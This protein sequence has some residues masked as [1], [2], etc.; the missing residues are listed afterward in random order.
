[1]VMLLFVGIGS[2]MAEEIHF[3]PSTYARQNNPSNATWDGSKTLSWN[4]S[5]GNNVLIIKNYGASTDLSEYHLVIKTSNLTA[6]FYRVVIFT[7]DNTNQVIATLSTT[8]TFYYKLY[9]AVPS[10]SVYKIAIAG[11]NVADKAGSVDIDDVYLYRADKAPYDNDGEYS[12]DLS[13]LEAAGGLSYSYDS[14]TGK[15]TLSAATASTAGT[16]TYTFDEDEVYDF[17]DVTQFT[18]TC[19][20]GNNSTTD[21]LNFYSYGSTNGSF[22]IVASRFSWNASSKNEQQSK[23]L[24][25]LGKLVW[26]RSDTNANT[27]DVVI[28]SIKFKT[29]ASL[30]KAENALASQSLTA[31]S[32]TGT[33]N[34]TNIGNSATNVQNVWGHSSVLANNYND[35]TGYKNITVTGGSANQVIR[36]LFNRA[37]DSSNLTTVSVGSSTGMISQDYT[38]LDYRITLDADGNGTFDFSKLSVAHLHAIKYVNSNQKSPTDITVGRDVYSEK[39]L[40]GSGSLYSASALALLNSEG[41]TVIDARSLGTSTELSVANPNCLILSK[42]KVSNTNNVIVDGTCANLVLTDGYPYEAPVDF[43]ATAASYTTTI[44]TT[45]QA[46]TLCLPFAATIPAEVDAYTL[47]FTSGTAATATS[48]E[49]TIPANT[50]VLLNG[51]GEQTFTGSGSID[52][53]AANTDGALTGVFKSTTVPINSYVLQNGASGL[54]FYKVASAITAKPFRAYLT[55]E[56]GSAREFFGIDFADDDITTGIRSLTPSPSPKGEGSIYTLN[57]Q[58]VAQPTKGLYIVNGKKYVIK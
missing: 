45:A 33:N 23:R 13:K 51:S 15:G 48:V 6:G 9:D 21:N 43:T 16:L 11:P 47:S 39:I 44:N 30:I 35:L 7:A 26:N 55:A 24:I 19:E 56:A 42:G 14:E 17:G 22:Q 36:F 2:V 46:G 25:G 20:S 50:P 53:D 29:T 3:D 27:G 58:R 34:I 1:M 37:T 49:T 28:T 38:N 5:A 32:Y 18:V 31:M 57:G 4:S 54:G 52:A 12:L 10:G 8:G 41:T 40:T